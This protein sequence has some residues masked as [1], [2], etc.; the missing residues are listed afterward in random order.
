MAL[1]AVTGVGTDERELGIAR[2]VRADAGGASQGPL[3]KG[4]EFAIVVADAWQRRG[5]G[6]LLLQCLRNAAII[7]GV[8]ELGGITLAT[9]SGM[10]RLARRLG[11]EIS[12]EPDDWTVRRIVWRATASVS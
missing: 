10:I 1:V 12:P 5:I 8:T 9:N 6:D 4:A 3:A 2:Y 11:F 7:A